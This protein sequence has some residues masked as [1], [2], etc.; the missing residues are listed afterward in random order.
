[1]PLDDVI[2]RLLDARGRIQVRTDTAWVIGD[3]PP[4]IVG[5][6]ERVL[7]DER[8]LG[9]SPQGIHARIDDRLGVG[10]RVTASPG[11]VRDQVVRPVAI[12]S[13]KKRDH[14]GQWNG[15]TRRFVKKWPPRD[16]A[17][18]LNNARAVSRACKPSRYQKAPTSCARRMARISRAR[19]SRE[20]EHVPQRRYSGRS[21]QI[22]FPTSN[23]SL[24]VLVQAWNR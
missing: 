3:Y 16:L 23:R 21:I 4:C 17:V 5:N 14:G 20:H 13:G 1:M 12:G 11:R 15:I 24:K 6:L 19:S 18:G 9:H 22:S 10:F 7:V 8:V 2:P